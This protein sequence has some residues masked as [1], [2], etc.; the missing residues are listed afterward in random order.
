[1]EDVIASGF[2]RAWDG[3]YL[4]QYQKDKWTN[5]TYW[6]YNDSFYWYISDSEYHYGDDHIKARMAYARLLNPRG[7]YTGFAGEPNGVVS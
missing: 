1:M 4:Y 6:I 3:T 5:G 7:N 2:N